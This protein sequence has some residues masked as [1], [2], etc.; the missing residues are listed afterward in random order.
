[1]RVTILHWLRGLPGP[2]W[3]M[4]LWSGAFLLA[5]VEAAANGRPGVLEHPI[6]SIVPA[7]I[8][9]AVLVWGPGTPPWFL[10]AAAV[11]LLVSSF[12]VANVSPYLVDV[13]ATAFGALAVV[14]YSGL[15]WRQG[16]TFAYAGGVSVGVLVA[17]QLNGMD[18]AAAD[19]WFTLTAMLFGTALA[20]N[21]VMARV[22]SQATHDPM[23]GLVNRVGLDQYVQLHLSPGRASLPRTMLVLDLDGFKKVND[24]SGHA[25]GDDLLRQ[26]TGAWR[27]VLRPDDLEVRTGGDEFLLI[28][29]QTEVDGVWSLV[30][31]LEAAHPAR[32]SHGAVDWAEDET[33]DAAMGRA[34]A[35]MYADKRR[36][37]DLAA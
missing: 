14:L 29:P 18:R 37:R 25:A 1:M 35:L 32:W 5:T 30:A 19:A 17:V 3:T 13:F 27:T 26:V 7:V 22:V 8:C 10:H 36:R 33:F 20:L 15:W 2:V 12:I 16:T 24:E 21:L 34:D 31:R 28:L 4:A 6:I 23:T 11:S 9:V